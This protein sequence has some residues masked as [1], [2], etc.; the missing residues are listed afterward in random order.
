MKMLSIH[1]LAVTALVALTTCDAGD[2]FPLSPILIMPAPTLSESTLVIPGPC[3]IFDTEP[4]YAVPASQNTSWD[5]LPDPDSVTPATP[6]STATVATEP[7]TELEYVDEVHSDS[8][9]TAVSPAG[10]VTVPN[11]S[12]FSLFGIVVL[13]PGVIVWVRNPGR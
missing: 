12:S 1:T 4:V 10:S 9:Q 2:R 6:E 11:T 5:S 7:A 8:H 3:P 13:V